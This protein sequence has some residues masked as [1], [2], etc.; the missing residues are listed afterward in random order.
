MLLLP[1]VKKCP[2]RLESK[3]LEEKSIQKSGKLKS[4]AESL[5]QMEKVSMTEHEISESEASTS[6]CS[7]KV[8]DK[9]KPE[10]SV[11]VL[12]DPICIMCILGLFCIYGSYSIPYVYIPIK[13]RLANT[14]ASTAAR[15]ISVAGIADISGGI[16]GSLIGSCT[17]FM[18][19][20]LLCVG[21]LLFGTSTMSFVIASSPQSTVV[22]MCC[23]GLGTGKVHIP[24]RYFIHNL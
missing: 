23:L 19:L 24:L 1:R 20:L 13:V 10:G 7:L 3:E 18:P 11:P 21:V 9:M 17:E 6:S 4:G 12:T 14:P 16:L 22:L 5:T 2:S 8:R 15:M